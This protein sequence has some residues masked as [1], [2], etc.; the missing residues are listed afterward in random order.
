MIPLLDVL[1]PVIEKALS[2]IPDPKQKAEAQL[3]LQEEINR[4][5]EA[6]LA[7]LTAVDAKQAETNTEEAKSTNLFVSGWRPWIGW[8]CGAAFT[9]AFVIEPFTLFVLAASGHT[10]ES[11]PKLDLSE[12]M[13]VLLGM[14]GLAGMRTWE[15]REG[16]HDKH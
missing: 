9:W 1:G 11:L 8:V 14:L 15:K 3:K 13:P 12:M 10:V 2:F 6:I 16:V 5:S 7:S 4:N